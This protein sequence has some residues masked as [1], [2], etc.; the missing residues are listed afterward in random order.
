MDRLLT[1]ATVEVLGDNIVK[2]NALII[3]ASVYLSKKDIDKV[4]NIVGE[5]PSRKVNTIEWLVDNNGCLLEKTDIV[6]RQVLD[7]IRIYR[8]NAK[9]VSYVSLIDIAIENYLTYIGLT[10]RELEELVI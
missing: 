5:Y 3:T 10:E 6:F 8:N 7:N 1:N 9:E 4:T 2:F